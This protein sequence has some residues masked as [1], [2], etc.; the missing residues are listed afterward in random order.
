ML[1]T[2]YSDSSIGSSMIPKQPLSRIDWRTNLSVI[3]RRATPPSDFLPIMPSDPLLGFS[4]MFLSSWIF[5]GC[6]LR[7]IIL[8]PES[9]TGFWEVLS[10]WLWG[11]IFKLRS[12]GFLLSSSDT[13]DVF[14]LELISLLPLRL[15]FLLVGFFKFSFVSS[16]IACKSR[17]LL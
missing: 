11:E 8:S 13:L 14:M 12:Q 15:I 5:G 7:T 1:D 17:S 9:E 6:F 3:D 2:T 10:S 16:L 4:S